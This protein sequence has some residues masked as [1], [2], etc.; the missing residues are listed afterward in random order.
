VLGQ[1]NGTAN[2]VL[3]LSGQRYFA[4]GEGVKLEVYQNAGAS[5]TIPQDSSSVFRVSF[6]R[7]SG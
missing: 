5:I 7:V 2:Q 3:A 6:A 4:V 1:Q